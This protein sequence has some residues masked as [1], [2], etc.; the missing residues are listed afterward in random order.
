MWRCSGCPGGGA[1]VCA[2]CS[3][4]LAESIFQHGGHDGTLFRSLF[5]VSTVGLDAFLAVDW[6]QILRD[7][8]IPTALPAGFKYDERLGTLVATECA[9]CSPT[10][11]K[12]TLQLDTNYRDASSELLT[13]ELIDLGDVHV[14]RSEDGARVSKH[15]RVLVLVFSS[16]MSRADAASF[17]W[18][19][20]QEDKHGDF[21]HVDDRPRL[22]QR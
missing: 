8:T 15:T 17:K 1:W 3:A 7:G 9:F 11:F 19:P 5:R 13:K 14:V 6:R 10:T 16:L 18:E 12:P 4:K 2:E 20:Y 22:T 21:L